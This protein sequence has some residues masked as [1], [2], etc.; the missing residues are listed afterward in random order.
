[1]EDLESQIGAI[2]NDPSM[3]E[4]L[5]AMA[6]SLSAPKEEPKQEQPSAPPI[7]LAM[8]Q[9]LS[10]LAGQSGIDKQQQ[11]LL[12]AL[13]PYLS[14]QRIEKLKKAMRAAKMAKLASGFLGANPF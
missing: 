1:M 8:V 3:M 14:R 6:Q 2:M 12:S 10:S 5:M 7:D 9:K 11:S 4:K 13:S